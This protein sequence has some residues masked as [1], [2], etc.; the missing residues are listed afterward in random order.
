MSKE[1]L[2]ALNGNNRGAFHNWL[3]TFKKEPRIA[4]YPSAGEDFRD[5][6]YLHPRYAALNPAKQLPEPRPP[7]IFLHTDYFPWSTSRFLDN[8]TIHLDGHTTV[9]V[10][11]IEQLPRCQLPLDD[12]I[13]EFPKGSHA[14][15]RVLF[16]EI[17]IQSDLLGK[18][19]VPVV[20]AFVENAA[21]CAQKALPHRARFS[22]VIHVRFGGGLGGGGFSKG[23]WL[24]HVLQ[25]LQCEVFLSD[26]R[27][28]LMSGDRRIY[29]L[30]P[31]LQRN[32]RTA[33]LEQIRVIQSEAWSN[34]GNVSWGVVT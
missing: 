32:G 18:F 1:L 4:W 25:A 13:V 10:R 7:D 22:H 29:A 6:L 11:S 23:K 2:L 28:G 16:L 19:S 17:E 31:S 24:L 15:G 5:L 9:S 20:Y 8:H 14:T 12:K 34:Y 3:K 21:F 30:Y 27:Y 33:Q 26:T